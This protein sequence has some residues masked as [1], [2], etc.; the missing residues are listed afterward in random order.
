MLAG[1][2]AR[3]RLA[4]A[5]MMRLARLREMDDGRGEAR[6]VGIGE[7]DR[8]ARFHDA[9]E[10]VGGAEVDAD[11]HGKVHGR[12]EEVERGIRSPFCLLI[13]LSLLISPSEG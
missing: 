7:E 2:T 1:A 11:D 10:G 12:K 13:L 4:G 8:E 3:I 6:S 9:D 5:P